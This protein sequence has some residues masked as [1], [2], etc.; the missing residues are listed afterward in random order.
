MAEADKFAGDAAVAPGGI[1]GGHV[2]DE[3]TK[4]HRG[5]GLAGRPAGLGPVAGDS[6]S[7]PTQQGLWGDKPASS[8]RS[9]QGRRDRTQQGSG[10]RRRRLVGCSGGAGL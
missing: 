5:A 3:T 1:V 6:A 4:F 8:L 2:D 9:R 7:V 10:P